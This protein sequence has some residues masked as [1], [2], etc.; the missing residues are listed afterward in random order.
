MVRSEREP[1][2]D[3]RHVACGVCGSDKQQL[4]GWRGGAAHHQ[5]GGIRVRIVRCGAC[6]HLYPDPMPF[7][8]KDLDGLYKDTSGYFQGHDVEAKKSFGLSLLS[9]FEKALERRGRYLDVGCGRGELLWA[10]REA[11]WEYEGVDPSSTYLG[12]AQQHLGVEGRIGTLEEAHFPDNHFDAISMG[13][14]IEHLYEPYKT[15]Q[16]V[17]R[18]L[19]PGGC[20]WLDAPNEDGLYM[21]IGNIYMRVLGRD[22]VI[23][24][25]PTFPPYHVQGFN[26]HSLK[27]LLARVGFDIERLEVWGAVWPFTGERSLRKRIEYW[28]AEFVN[29]MGNR[30]GAG[31]YMNVWARKPHDDHL[32]VPGSN[33][34]DGRD[35]RDTSTYEKS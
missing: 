18:V 3:L 26:Q 20:L 1:A 28:L 13:G 16:E 33:I 8:A 7:P 9:Q 25:A 22:W 31:T 5:G 27:K 2:F 12:W 10:A 17:W 29:W 34:A 15:L 35:S 6:S 30:C 4:L 24:L 19:R 32:N 21:R 14:V 23:N 11:G